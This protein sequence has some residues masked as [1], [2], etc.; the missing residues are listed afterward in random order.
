[1]EQE[2]QNRFASLSRFFSLLINDQEIMVL[3][4]ERLGYPQ[5]APDMVS[6][7]IK[8]IIDYLVQS[9]RAGNFSMT[10]RSSILMQIKS[11]YFAQSVNKCSI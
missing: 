7:K 10:T 11:W 1:M 4:R 9:M 6:G 2:A 5:I 8:A 3:E